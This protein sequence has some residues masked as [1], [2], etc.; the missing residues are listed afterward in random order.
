MKGFI[1]LRKSIIP[2]IDLRLKFNIEVENYTTKDTS[3]I[4]I[5]LKMIKKKLF[6]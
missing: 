3:V 5:N 2:I 1:N 6:K 4:T